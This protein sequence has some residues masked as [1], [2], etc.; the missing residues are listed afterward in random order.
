MLFVTEVKKLVCSISYLLFVAVLVI[1]LHS[2]GVLNFAGSKVSEPRPGAFYG[3]TQKEIPEVIMPAALLRLWNEFRVNDYHTYPV[4][5][6]KYVRLSGGEQEEIAEIIAEI[7]GTDKAV[8][9]ATQVDFTEEDDAG[10][11]VGEEEW[12]LKV[13]SGLEY[14]EF[15]ALMQKADDILGGGSD[16]H[17]D[18]L[19]QFGAVPITYEEAVRS[20]SLFLD[21][22]QVTG[23]YARLFADYAVT[24]AA[25]VMPVFLAVF[26]CMKDRRAKM[27]ELIYSRKASAARIVT[28]RYA[29]VIV[30]VML[31][32]IVLSY[33][34]NSSVWGA[35]PGVRLNYLAPLQYDLVWIA[36]S[37]MIAA[38]VGMCLT[39]LT[40]TPIAIL[41]QG[42]W[43]LADANKGIRSVEE[44]YALLRLSPRH[45][46]GEMSYF[47]IQDYI[48]NAGRL[49]A[50]R[51]VFAGMSVLL[52]IVTIIIYSVK[53]KGRLHGTIRYKRA[54]SALGGD[55]YQYQA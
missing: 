18:R 45:N 7:T 14:S 44:G 52:L 1:D 49:A 42:L 38:A 23:G 43:W 25:S 16:Y 6:I 46:A 2:Q 30:C 31:P 55:S 8:V 11:A 37:V 34:S 28:A 40:N 24:M 4:G 29:A 21:R 12:G 27:T 48:D 51:L 41:V 33:V 35:Y 9:I 13:R 15:A 22:D 5:L 36:P 3:M 53:R 54:V 50:N 32:V 39:E 26:L 19:I 47:R 20:Y 17:A 10:F